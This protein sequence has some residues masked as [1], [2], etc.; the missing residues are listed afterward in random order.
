M[1]KEEKGGSFSTNGMVLGATAL[2]ALAGGLYFLSKSL[3]VEKK[4]SESVK[5]ERK[6]DSNTRS[7]DYVIIDT[8]NLPNKEDNPILK[9]TDFVKGAQI[10]SGNY[11]NV[12]KGVCKGVDVAIKELKSDTKETIDVNFQEFKNEITI[13]R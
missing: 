6:E 13:M 11:G 5:S 2:V 12:F 9:K 1:K 8:K 3:V 4:K 7:E 10:G